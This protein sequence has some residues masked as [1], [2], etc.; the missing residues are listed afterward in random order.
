MDRLLATLVTRAFRR[1]LAGE[2]LWIAVGVAAWV[3]RR[4]RNRRDDVVWS[5]RVEPGQRLLVTTLAP[6]AEP[7]AG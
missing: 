3:V 5:G 6:G 2:P 7:P 1:G 4:S